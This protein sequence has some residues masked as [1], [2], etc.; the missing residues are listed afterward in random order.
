MKKLHVILET[1]EG[2]GPPA[3]PN[4]NRFSRASCFSTHHCSTALKVNLISVPDI[5]VS[6][7]SRQYIY[8]NYL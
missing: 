3:S 1:R 5:E 6:G 2:A 4:T 8:I 7:S